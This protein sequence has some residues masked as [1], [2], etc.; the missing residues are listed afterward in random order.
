MDKFFRWFGLPGSLVL[1]SLLSALALTLALTD[2]TPVRWLCFAAM[3][4][5]SAG[6]VFLSHRKKLSERFKHCFEIGAALF[7]VSHLL[8]ALCF[9]MKTHL[10]LVPILNGGAVIALLLGAAAAAVLIHL[11]VRCGR[12][13]KLPLPLIYLSVILINCAAVLSYVCAQ[14]PLSV[15][16]FCAAA[17]ILSFMISDFIIGL[18]FACSI[19]RYDFLVWWFYPIGQIL[20]ILAA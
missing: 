19:H 15:S 13:K 10:Q 16:A 5:S 1:T 4:F 12:A 9:G 8:Y 11:S 14:N 7:M 18:G 3:A 20:L 6:D 17:G 2:P